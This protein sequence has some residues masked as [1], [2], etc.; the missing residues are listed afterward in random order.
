MEKPSRRQFLKTAAISSLGSGL[1]L[2]GLQA[3]TGSRA[4]ARYLFVI[5]ANGGGDITE[6]LLPIVSGGALSFPVAELRSIANSPFVV[7]VLP[8]AAFTLM[9]AR[10]A[11]NYQ[12]A[13]FLTKHKTDTVVM[14]QT[15]SSVN[16][17][18]AAARALTG[19]DINRGQTLMEAASLKYG[20][21]LALPNCS[22]ANGHY[23][24]HGS[25]GGLP[26]F[27]RSETVIDPLT[28]GFSTHAIKGVNRAPSQESINFARGLRADLEKSSPIFQKLK[29]HETLAHYLENRQTLINSIEKGDYLDKLNLSQSSGAD[30]QKI[31]AAFP[32]ITSDPLQAQAAL[33][34]LL[35]KNN[36]SCALTISPGGQFLQLNGAGTNVAT[37][38]DLSHTNH[39]ETQ[40]VMWNRIMRT[41]DALIDLLKSQDVDNDPAQG[42][43]WDRSL[44]FIATEFGRT[45]FQP[46]RGGASG[47]N[48]NNG[49]ILISPLLK[50]N[51]I[52]GGVNGAT[53]ATFGFDRVTGAPRPND[54]AAT[55]N[56]K[57]VYSVICQALGISF[58]G[59][60]DIPAMVKA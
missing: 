18:V 3:Q 14:T 31:L 54:P 39:R 33:A 7:P 11:N 53:G 41:A 22:M 58:E 10:F 56:E 50:G 37:G 1:S 51:T 21:G 25:D 42:K 23:L 36:L 9:Q 52:Y 12:M 55:M 38:F 19:D 5:A 35:A 17:N 60:R 2:N 59:R 16:H 45:R 32:G 48:L 13:T 8:E 15:N 47:H 43:M 44:I 30:Y 34:F 57:D 24:L 4:P 46:A 20:Q 29:N 26:N 6:S 27:A 28:F 40:Y 49:S